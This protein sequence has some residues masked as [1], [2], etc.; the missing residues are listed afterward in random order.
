MLSASNQPL[1][2]SVGASGLAF[3][4]QEAEIWALCKLRLSVRH[5]GSFFKGKYHRSWN[6]QDAITIG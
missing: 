1:A 6:S 5:R 3:G 4:F 2:S